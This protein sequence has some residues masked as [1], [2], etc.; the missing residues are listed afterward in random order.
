MSAELLKRAVQLRQ[1][2][3]H[4]ATANATQSGAL[5]DGIYGVLC[6]IVVNLQFTNSV[7]WVYLCP[8]T[9]AELEGVN[10]VGLMMHKSL[11]LALIE[12]GDDPG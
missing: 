1:A 5:R 10:V 8:A 11:L 2:W 7:L 12:C 3:T 6:V 9:A 4:N